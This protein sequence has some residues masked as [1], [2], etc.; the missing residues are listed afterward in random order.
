[1]FKNA[2]FFVM[3]RNEEDD[4]YINRIKLDRDAQQELTS[5]FIKEVENLLNFDVVP[6]DGSY[7]TDEGEIHQISNF[8]VSEEICSA[9]REPT[10][11]DELKSNSED[12]SKIISIFTGTTDAKMIVFQKFNK[13]QYIANKG[14]SLFHSS[15][16][17]ELLKG[18]GINILEKI[19]CIYKDGDLFFKS[20]FTAR[21]IF[22]LSNHYREAT[23]ADINEFIQSD[24]ITLESKDHFLQHADSW[25]RRKVALIK[26]SE[27]FINYTPAQIRE[28]AATYGLNIDLRSGK[29]GEQESLI[30]PQDKKELKDVLRFLDEEIYK[31]A[32]SNTTYLTNSKRKYR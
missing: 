21:Q 2:S 15:G 23:D 17:F 28:R 14:I 10:S 12:A 16:T 27:T 5:M 3:V 25:V 24:L 20:F 18:F 8:Q 4:L 22:D 13:T 30:L 26:D 19:D 29:D 32:L 6:F 11:I 7:K 1:M 9:L 31:G